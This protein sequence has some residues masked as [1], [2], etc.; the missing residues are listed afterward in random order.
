MACNPCPKPPGSPASIEVHPHEAPL[1]RARR[2]PNGKNDSESVCK[3]DADPVISD[4]YD[5]NLRAENDRSSL[6]FSHELGDTTP[7]M[8]SSQG[9][10]RVSCY[11]SSF[12]DE[13]TFV[14][15]VMLP[16]VQ[17]GELPDHDRGPQPAQ[18]PGGPSHMSCERPGNNE[19]V[20][21]VHVRRAD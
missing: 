4:R 7:P 9:D 12:A 1:I 2:V 19:K 16:S 17:R 6:W 21:S 10:E 13:S 14:P 3:Q 20:T 18:I 11:L 8:A 15:E 5:Q